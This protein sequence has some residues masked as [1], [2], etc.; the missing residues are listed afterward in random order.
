[1][2][3]RSGLDLYSS[4]PSLLA[5]SYS[6]KGQEFHLQKHA[7]ELRKQAAKRQKLAEKE[8][9]L[10]GTDEFEK[11]F[12]DTY[13]KDAKNFEKIAKLVEKGKLRAAARKAEE[14]DSEPQDR[15]PPSTWDFLQGD[16]ETWEGEKD[17]GEESRYYR[18]MKEAYKKGPS[19]K[20]KA[21]YAKTKSGKMKFVKEYYKK[22]KGKFTAF[23]KG[24]NK[25]GKT[26]SGKTIWSRW[27]NP[28]HA[29]FNAK[30]HKEAAHLHMKMAK[31]T[32]D[33]KKRATHLKRA[34]RHLRSAQEVLGK[35]FGG[36]MEKA[37][38]YVETVRSGEGPEVPS[39]NG[40]GLVD[41]KLSPDDTIAPV[42][43]EGMDPK[44]MPAFRG[45][46]LDETLFGQG[47]H[48]EEGG[49][50]PATESMDG[51]VGTSRVGNEATQ[52]D[53]PDPEEKVLSEDD[54][55]A[56]VISRIR[57]NSF[58]NLTREVSLLQMSGLHSSADAQASSTQPWQRIQLGEEVDTRVDKDSPNLE[59]LRSGKG[60]TS[61]DLIN[62]STK[63]VEF[64]LTGKRSHKA[65]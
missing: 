60:S 45:V 37:G 58:Q 34:G 39:I 38:E 50:S 62:K 28:G 10:K 55:M 1:M 56:V 46:R 31:K 16:D 48:G 57:E 33:D 2:D 65:A 26:N 17:P 59:N 35:S 4:P 30:E 22:A 19:G 5:K 23:K 41:W 11:D 14:L 53:A 21:H 52:L 25:M 8:Y 29:D 36:D 44:D 47:A 15:I 3:L 32:D 40:S 43:L 7:A 13:R 42:L 18:Y 54:D 49:G 64:L 63:E 61:P 6:A 12:Y 27:S 20:V 24:G 9:K 51:N